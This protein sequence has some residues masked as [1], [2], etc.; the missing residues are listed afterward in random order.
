MIEI[1]KGSVCLCFLLYACKLDWYERKIPNKFFVWMFIYLLPFIIT[2]IYVKGI[3]YLCYTG[4]IVIL[5]Y[6]SVYFFFRIGM[7][8][9]ADA[10]VLI[11]ISCVFPFYPGFNI[12][13]LNTLIF[14]LIIISVLPV[15]FVI[16]NLKTLSLHEIFENPLYL[17]IGY[18]YKILNLKNKHIRLIE[19]HVHDGGKVIFMFKSTGFEINDVMIENLKKLELLDL[20]PS[21]VWVTPGIPFII[22][23][24]ISYIIN[25]IFGEI[26]F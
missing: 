2:E 22:P 26:I 11:I 3:N 1:L 13:V 18:K 7:F 23:I 8:G 9:G 24:T 12:P 4:I 14:S 5:T 19:N 20:I 6:V 15:I 16:Y 17:L 10:K 25:V 21:K